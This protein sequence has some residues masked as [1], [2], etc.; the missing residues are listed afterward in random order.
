[1]QNLSTLLKMPV[2]S[3]RMSSLLSV[4]YVPEEPSSTCQNATAVSPPDGLQ[5]SSISGP[6][7]ISAPSAVSSPSSVFTSSSVSQSSVPKLPP[8]V[9][10]VSPDECTPDS[11]TSVAQPSLISALIS[12]TRR[13][14]NL[15]YYSGSMSSV[16]YGGLFSPSLT[17]FS[18]TNQMQTPC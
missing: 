7:S 17:P 9:S 11:A 16:G 3:W 10:V 6:S 14:I 13:Q 2:T 5:S 15:G 18:R 1:M 4:P 8:F 12:I